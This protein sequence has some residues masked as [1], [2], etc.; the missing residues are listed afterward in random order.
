ML[1]EEEQKFIIYWEDN[2]L[3][4]KKKLKQLLLGLPIG[5]LFT[6]PVLLLL[7]SGR[8]W[9]RKADM[10]ANTKLNPVV[11]LIAIMIIV[12]FVAVFYKQ[13][14]WEM[15]EQQYLELKAKKKKNAN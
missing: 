1:T 9:Y 15:K 8:Y 14:E 12:I 3:K 5:L 4:E 10:I 13:H 6:L 11:L 2:R 7:F